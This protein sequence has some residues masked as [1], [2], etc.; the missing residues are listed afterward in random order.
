MDRWRIWLEYYDK[1]GNVTGYGVYSKSYV[2]EGWAIRRA[3]QLWDN[4]P[5]VKWYVSALWNTRY[6]MGYS[7]L[8]D[9]KR[10]PH[11]CGKETLR[12]RRTQK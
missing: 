5:L 9:Q 10:R 4:N 6:E 12:R 2:H 7:T 1:D 8:P 11:P 3:R